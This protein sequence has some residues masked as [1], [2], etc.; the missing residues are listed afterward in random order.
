MALRVP[1]NQTVTSKYTS[2]GEYVIESTYAKYKGYYYELS[3]KLFAGKEYDPNAPVI[4]KVTKENANSLLTNK[5]TYLYGLLSGIKLLNTKPVSHI[6]QKTKPNERYADRYF[7]Q[8]VNDNPPLIKEI[9]KDTYEQFQTDPLYKSTTIKWDTIGS[10]EKT[11]DL[12]DK[13]FPGIKSFL[14][15]LNYSPFGEDDEY[16][17]TSTTVTPP[18]PPLQPLVS[19]GSVT[20][21][22]KPQDIIP[23]GPIYI[24]ASPIVSQPPDITP[25]APVLSNLRYLSTNDVISINFN[26]DSTGNSPI[27]RIGTSYNTS[28][29]LLY[30]NALDTGNTSLGSYLQNRT[31]LSPETFY[32]YFAYA[33][34]DA[35]F[36]GSVGPNTAW[37]L[38]NPPTVQAS[39]LVAVT[40]SSTEIRLSWTA[41][42]WPGSGAT[43]KQYIILR[44][45]F[46]NTPNI[47]NTNGQVLTVDAITTIQA[48][49]IGFG[50]TEY[51]ASGLT[52]NTTYTFKVIPVTW[53][54]TNIRTDAPTA[55]YLTAGAPTATATLT[56]PPTTCTADTWDIGDLYTDIED[57]QIGYIYYKDTCNIYVVGRRDL[58]AENTSLPSFPEVEPQWGCAGDTVLVSG[59]NDSVGGGFENTRTIVEF[60]CP[61][62]VIAPFAAQ[63]CYDY[64]VGG[65][66]WNL[67]TAGDWNQMYIVKDDLINAEA[68]ENKYYWSSNEYD[69][70][71]AVVVNPYTGT[72]GKLS[73]S[74]TSQW[75]VRPVAKIENPRAR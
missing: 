62:T 67:P 11:L 65:I 55:N 3:G 26:V 24:N 34:N 13:Q 4:I 45:V 27:N 48:E 33:M 63:L 14:E 41:A 64:R 9:N 59:G 37:T 53:S 52:S 49:G 5:S 47:T 32:Y 61:P 28:P 22:P 50:T 54:G 42:T 38:S 70:S 8:R 46:P 51:T 7:I 2:D 17:V 36:T 74:K 60:G 23:I 16:T 73:L 29:G 18:L 57:N 68:I 21:T 30:T 69:K 71:F 25:T 39:N 40:G 12:L 72:A 6:F 44:S 35:G 31:G 20:D 1:L 66:Q 19:S 56:T 43:N 10:N 15:E 75:S 58:F